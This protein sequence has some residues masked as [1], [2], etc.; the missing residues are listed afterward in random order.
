MTNLNKEILE[1]AP[2]EIPAA[3]VNFPGSQINL[4]PLS[5]LAASLQIVIQKW[6]NSDHPVSVPVKLTLLLNGTRVEEVSF[7]TPIDPGLFPFSVYILE[8]YLQQEGVHEVSYIVNTAGNPATSE[9]TPFT[10]D[11]TAPNYG[12]PGEIVQF[13][14]EIIRDGI[15]QKY[16]DEHGD[17]VLGIIPVYLQQ[18]ACDS[19]ECHYGSFTNSPVIITTVHDSNSP[20]V[21]KLSGE[22]I[23]AHGSGN[24]LAFYRIKDRAGNY[25]PFSA[26][27]NIHVD[28]P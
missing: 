23:R 26:F 10:I 25:G 3:L 24:K 13:P 9:S 19:I 12:N 22:I 20:T 5:A 4:L 16:L 11:R 7:T 2:P 28:L 17:E 21:I 27:V 1:L 8:Q 15:T 6:A 14:P 18:R